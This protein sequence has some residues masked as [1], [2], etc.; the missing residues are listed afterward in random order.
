MLDCPD[1][2]GVVV[3]G[4][5]VVVESGD[6]GV[7]VEPGVGVVVEPGDGVVLGVV[8]V[9]TPGEDGVNGVD[10][11]GAVGAAGDVGLVVLGA[12][13][14]VGTAFGVEGVVESGVVGEVLLGAVGE[15]VPGVVV[16]AGFDGEL[17][18]AFPGT[19]RPGASVLGDR[20]VLDG[21]DVPDCAIGLSGDQIKAAINGDVG[22]EGVAVGAEIG[23]GFAGFVFAMEGAV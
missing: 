6:E 15:V 8:G 5:G 22:V 16:L 3:L 21:V 17:E 19:E 9:G 12:E 23:F 7:V 20:G 14:V 10:E 1:G 2:E 11:S 18:G 13:G 4:A